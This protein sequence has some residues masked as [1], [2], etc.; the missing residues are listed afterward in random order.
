MTTR[1]REVLGQVLPAASF[2]RALRLRRVLDL[3]FGFGERPSPSSVKSRGWG[4]ETFVFWAVFLAEQDV[5]CMLKLLDPL[6]DLLERVCLP[7]NQLVA[8]RNFVC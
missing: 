5:H 4:G 7:A 8:E 1:A 6:L 2:P 3:D